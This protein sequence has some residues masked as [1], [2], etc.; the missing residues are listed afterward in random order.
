MRRASGRP[1]RRC[2]AR[3]TPSASVATSEEARASA[4]RVS[5]QSTPRSKRWLDSVCSACRR[6]A[7]RI[8][9]G[10]EV[11]AL[12]EDAP[13]LGRDL[14]L[15]AAH[16]ARERDGALAVAD[17][18]IVLE[19]RAVHAVERPQLLSA[20]G[21]ADDDRAPAHPVEIERVHRVAELE[22]DEVGHVDDVRDGP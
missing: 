9:R 4:A 12:E 10:F 11:R 16:H 22:H 1:R 15:A 20:P 8:P 6:A 3:A 18:E 7:R 17:D 2:V 14:A 13:R 21:A 5:P 19:E